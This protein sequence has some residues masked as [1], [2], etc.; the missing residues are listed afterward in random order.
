[1]EMLDNPRIVMGAKILVGIGFTQ[2]PFYQDVNYITLYIEKL[3][4]P[5][6]LY[7]LIINVE[8]SLSY[9]SL[10]CYFGWQQP[11]FHR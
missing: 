5:L 9:E 10:H 6:N 7:S 11:K 4:V 8:T 2:T 1:M 3:F